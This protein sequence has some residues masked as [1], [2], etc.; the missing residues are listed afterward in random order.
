MSEKVCGKCDQTLPVDAFPPRRNRCKECVRAYAR[1]S[2]AHRLVT[3]PGYREQLN[4]NNR[5]F[6]KRHKKG[7]RVVGRAKYARIH[8]NVQ[9]YMPRRE[10]THPR[11]PGMRTCKLCHTVKLITMFLKDHT[12]LDKRAFVCRECVNAAR[13]ER[14]ERDPAYRE[15]IRLQR[16]VGA[17]EA[18]RLVQAMTHIPAPPPRPQLA[19]PPAR[20]VRPDPVSGRIHIRRADVPAHRAEL[21]RG[22]KTDHGRTLRG[23]EADQLLAALYTIVEGE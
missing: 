22:W 16:K 10:R 2:R 12:I 9:P 6:R 7:L 23:R 11:V 13:A 14:M 17:V 18:R 1:D 8:P 3:V 21:A 19:Q 20:V 4:A 5:T 15:Y